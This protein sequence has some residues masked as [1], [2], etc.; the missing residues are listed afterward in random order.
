MLQKGC[1]DMCGH[2]AALTTISQAVIPSSDS[3]SET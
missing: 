3:Q 2:Y 1:A